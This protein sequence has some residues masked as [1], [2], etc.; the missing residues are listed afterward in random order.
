V[1][2]SQPQTPAHNGASASA[3]TI[4]AALTSPVASGSFV[5]GCVTHGNASGQTVSSVT[6][7]KNNTYN[8]S[9]EQQGGS[10]LHTLTLFWL[11]NITNT[12]LTITATFSASSTHR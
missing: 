5:V 11:T 4:A 2:F 8:L 12:P 9:S 1:T 7:D 3:G 6:D 10:S